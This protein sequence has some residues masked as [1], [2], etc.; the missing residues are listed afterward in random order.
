MLRNGEVPR[1]ALT[2]AEPGLWVSWATN[3]A[4]QL[5]KE[6]AARDGITVR[7]VGPAG[8]YRDLFVQGDMRRRPQLYNINPAMAV[9]L[10]AP[11]YSTHGAGTAIDI[12][13][14]HVDGP[15]LRWLLKNMHRFGFSR[16]FG[17]KDRNHLQHD[18]TIFE[19]P[20]ST[21]PAGAG[22]VVIVPKE[23]TLSAA[24]VADIKKHI[25]TEANRVIGR[26]RQATLPVVY[27]RS[28]DGSM[29]AV[30]VDAGYW[31]E[32]ASLGDYNT[33]K[34]LGLISDAAPV[35]VSPGVFNGIKNEARQAHRAGS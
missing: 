11:G 4:Y 31:R 33:L 22:P 27:K 34:N 10:S 1:E 3:A 32:L 35:T 19:W 6:A 16:P 30:D 21:S 8:A 17:D 15:I 7:I 2:E 18:G 24:E 12:A 9:K 26:L 29:A 28:S 5:M 23:D 25:T 13:G 20:V 14:A